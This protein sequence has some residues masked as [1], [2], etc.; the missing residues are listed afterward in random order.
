M[1]STSLTPNRASGSSLRLFNTAFLPTC[2][3]FGLDPHPWRPSSFMPFFYFTGDSAL[4]LLSDCSSPILL[5]H[6]CQN[7]DPELLRF[8]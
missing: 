6:I 5:P 4:T 8:P 2:I 7:I 1:S 3:D